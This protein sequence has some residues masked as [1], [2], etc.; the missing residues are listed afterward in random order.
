MRFF[1]GPA[2]MVPMNS[3]LEVPTLLIQI[4]EFPILEEWREVNITLVPKL[5]QKYLLFLLLLLRLRFELRTLNLQS[6]HSTG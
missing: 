4:L 5:K 3:L 1:A 6:R 2:P